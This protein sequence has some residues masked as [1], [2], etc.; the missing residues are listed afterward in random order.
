[1]LFNFLVV[2]LLSVGSVVIADETPEVLK[3]AQ[4]YIA[5][6]SE[7]DHEWKNECHIDSG[8]GC[9]IT[10]FKKDETT[11]VF[12]GGETRCIFS[13]TPNFAFQVIFNSKFCYFN[14]AS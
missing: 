13:N 1:M 9:S 14:I 5:S 7:Y 12:P 4:E 10:G 2:A 11:M 8:E 3:E 6:L